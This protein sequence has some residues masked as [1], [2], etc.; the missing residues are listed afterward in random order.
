MT[1]R[2]SLR[3]S[4]LSRAFGFAV[5]CLLGAAAV[6]SEA[7][8]FATVNG[9]EI[10]LAEYVE[11]LRMSSR[12]T[13][14]H[15]RPP[16]AELNAF[17]VEVGQKLIDSVLLAQEAERR[18]VEADENW[19]QAELTLIE[20]RY[21]DDES[22]IES[23]EEIVLDLRRRLERK[24]RVQSLEKKFR[25]INPP[26]PKQL[27]EYYEKHPEM[28]TSPEQVRVSM[29]LLRVDPWAGEEA[30]QAALGEAQG[31]EAQLREGADFAELARLRS[32]DGSAEKGG[33]LGYAHKGMLGIAAEEAITL[34]EPGQISPPITVLE[35]IGLFR[36]DGRKPAELNP[37]SK[38]R[39]RAE[40]LWLRE[41]RKATRTR[42]L[43]KLRGGAKVEIHD[44][45]YLQ[46]LNRSEEAGENS[47]E[48]V[49]TGREKDVN[50]G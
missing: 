50:G 45:I 42:L 23:R 12:G 47:H 44:P 22:W 2:A 18:G 27:Q 48:R 39:E 4:L 14:Y 43:A 3:T 40:E 29:I 33:D 37:L 38:V 10:A 34:L 46:L 26:T 30:W 36:L 13:F 16:E 11:T 9:V 19:V 5:A 17:K 41:E 24:S 1:S 6:A 21:E 31:I 7:P 25:R 28:F 32:Q 15:G 35:G 20:S 8:L 49:E